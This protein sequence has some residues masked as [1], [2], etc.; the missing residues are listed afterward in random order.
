MQ[1]ENLKYQPVALAM[2]AAVLINVAVVRFGG[3]SLSE[4][5]LVSV[6][7]FVQAAAGVVSTR[8]TRSKASVEEE[9]RL[10][11]PFDGAGGP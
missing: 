11:G 3:A 4:V 6:A 7:L 1:L 9:H 10:H 2:A 8:W 5:E